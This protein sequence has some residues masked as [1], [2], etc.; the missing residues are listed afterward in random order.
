M[1]GLEERIERR[2]ERVMGVREGLEGALVV[3]GI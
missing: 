1:D 2:V 3:K